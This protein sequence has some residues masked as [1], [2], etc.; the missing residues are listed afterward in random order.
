MRFACCSELEPHYVTTYLT[1]LAAAFNSWYANE[2]MI[3][4][5]N[6]QYGVLLT[7]AVEQTLS[8]RS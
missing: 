6:P 8:K 1:E 5:N 3:D 4:G 2:R 7:Q